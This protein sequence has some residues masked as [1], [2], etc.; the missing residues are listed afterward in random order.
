MA[1]E[2]GII[3]GGVSGIGLETA[4]RLNATGSWTLHLLDRNRAAADAALHAVPG[5]TFHEVDLTSYDTQAQAF[6]AMTLIILLLATVIATAYLALHYM[7][8]SPHRGK[9]GV[10]V[11]TGS[12][13]GLYAASFQPI[14]GAAKAST[15]HFVRGVASPLYHNDRIRICT[16][17]PG[18][19]HTNML[20]A[21]E[22][23]AFPPEFF[24]PVESL[25]QAVEMVIAGGEM[26]DC[27]GR[28]AVLRGKDWGFTVEVYGRDKLYFR[29]QVDFADGDIRTVIEVAS[30]DNA[31]AAGIAGG[32]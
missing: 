14:Y 16:V 4:K 12:I 17:C 19:V 6:Q 32:S 21:D 5:A 30:V 23:S 18:N 25:A 15:I 22:W 1:K 13:G 31:V 26:V 9:G 10:I 20:R 11:L 2:I 8:L 27:T 7:R 28:L 24:S 29:D 3:T